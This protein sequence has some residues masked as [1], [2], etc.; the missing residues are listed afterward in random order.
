MIFTSP[1]NEQAEG[2]VDEPPLQV[3]S[4]YTWQVEEHPSP[5]IKFPSSQPKLNSLPS[6]Q[7]YKQIPVESR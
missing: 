4:V 2:V 6:P 1:E 7:I 5:S 3:K